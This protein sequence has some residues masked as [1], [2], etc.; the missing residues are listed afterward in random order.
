MTKE[1]DGAAQRLMPK[2]A[3]NIC[4][5]S[6]RQTERR[7]DV[8]RTWARRAD[9]E[10]QTDGGEREEGRRGGERAPENFAQ[11]TVRERE[12]GR[13]EEEEWRSSSFWPGDAAAKCAY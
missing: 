6:Q 3:G 1:E 2:R 9:A 10:G 8:R 13:E 11:K 4:K 12:R 7:T 5:R